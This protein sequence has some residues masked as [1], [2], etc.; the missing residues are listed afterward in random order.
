[1]GQPLDV[2]AYIYINMTILI[3]PLETCIEIATGLMSFKI[4]G[5]IMPQAVYNQTATGR[6]GP[7]F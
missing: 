1:M 7:Y 6:M 4:S 3:L 2:W 5:T